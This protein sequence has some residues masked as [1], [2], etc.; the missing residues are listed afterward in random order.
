MTFPEN[1]I[2]P[3]FPGFPDPVWTLSIKCPTTL[4]W[5]LSWE[6]T[7]YFC[8]IYTI[9]IYTHH[10]MSAPAEVLTLNSVGQSGS[11]VQSQTTKPHMIFKVPLVHN[12]IIKWK[13][14]LCHWPFVRGIHRWPVNSPHKGQRR[15]AL[16][17]SL[18][19]SWINFSV[20]NGEAGDLRHHCAHYDITVM[21]WKFQI[22]SHWSDDIN[23]EI[24]QN[25]T[26]FCQLQQAGTFF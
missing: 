15:R 22:H 7:D 9:Y 6:N 17:F 24:S 18:I 26:A 20:N 13:H 8:H 11:G 16:M 23:Q 3:G 10:L 2:F 12:D 4:R 14:F 25:I 5:A 21:L 1:V 19:C